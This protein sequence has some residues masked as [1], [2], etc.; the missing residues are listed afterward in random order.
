MRLP[1]LVLLS[2]IAAFFPATS[3]TAQPPRAP[4]P[5]PYRPVAVI[6]PTALDDASFEAFRKDFAGVAKNRVYAELERLVTTQGFFWD[7]DF[8]NGFDRRKPAV[9]NLA[10]ALRL[11]RHMGD[12][13]I[14]LARFAA[15]PALAPL[16]SRYDVICGPAQPGYDAVEFDRLLDA[17]RTD[18]TD[19]LYPRTDKVAV[20]A[21]PQPN[22]AVIDTLG[23]HF[24]WMLGHAGKDNEREALRNVWV[25]VATPAGKT[26]F[27][28][29]DALTSLYVERLCYSKDTTGRWHIA[30]YIG[31]GD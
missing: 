29:P 30:G 5:R 31:G 12:G 16:T 19:W 14:A 2:V 3:A 4:A 21:A 7:R 23:L 26:G 28:A 6:L 22:A 10:A 8:G 24:V 20:R 15:E 9:D 13:W 1:C 18:G 11:E 25:R 17:T 27:V